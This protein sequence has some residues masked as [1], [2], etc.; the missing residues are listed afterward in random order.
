MKIAEV[1]K[2]DFILEQLTSGTKPDVLHELADVILGERAD[3]NPEGTVN[4][5]LEREK[6]GS[7]GIGDG[8]AI[9]H[10]KLNIIDALAIS[11]GRSQEGIDFNAMD[12]KPVHLFFLLLAPENAAGQHLKMLAKLSRMLKDATF[13]KNLLEATSTEDLY[14]I[15]VDK[16]DTC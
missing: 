2:K 5:L 3:Y 6:L 11:F 15:I 12:G 7:T 8:I 13:R 1:L 4:I 14:R 16:D 10:G 9:P